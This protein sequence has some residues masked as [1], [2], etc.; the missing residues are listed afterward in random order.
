MSAPT[1]SSGYC[2]LQEGPRD[3]YLTS[4]DIDGLEEVG[5]NLTDF[6]LTTLLV[7]EHV[8]AVAIGNF[9]KSLWPIYKGNLQKMFHLFLH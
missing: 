6:F 9:T 8:M 1:C 4:R 3:Y 2:R 7:G 5:E